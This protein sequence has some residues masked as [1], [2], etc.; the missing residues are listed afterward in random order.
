ML[1]VQVLLAFFAIGLV[2][3][4]GA[5]FTYWSV[6]RA[7]AYVQRGE[8]ADRTLQGYIELSAL[9]EQLLRT[10]ADASFARGTT[11]EQAAALRAQIQGKLKAIRSDIVEEAT[12]MARDPAGRQTEHKE[13]ITLAFLDS[14]L[15]QALALADLAVK[16][17]VNPQQ[18]WAAGLE[19]LGNT[20]G[21]RFQPQLARL[22][23][24][25]QEQIAQA[26]AVAE[27]QISRLRIAALIYAVASFLLLAGLAYY[28]SSRI[29]LP[30]TALITGTRT[31]A[32]GDLDARVPVTRADEFGQIAAN[33]NAIAQERQA[34]HAQLLAQQGKL[35]ASVNARTEELRLAM[36]RL[37]TSDKLRRELFADISHE[38]RTP[39]TAIRG[40]AEI[41]LRSKTADGGFYRA[42]LARVNDVSVQFARLIDDLLFVS[43][44]DSG[45]HRMNMRVVVLP[46][47]LQSVC[48]EARA[49]AVGQ[50]LEATIVLEPGNPAVL[51]FG[52][53]DRLH[54]LF[55]I[56]IDNAICYSLDA[57]DVRVAYRIEGDRVSVTVADRG[58]GIPQ[59]DLASVF[60]RFHRGTDAQRRNDEGL[61]LGLPIAKAIVDA[62]G[63]SIDIQ[64]VPNE[65]TTVSVTLGV[66]HAPRTPA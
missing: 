29:R 30:F 33:I 9:S 52:D 23:R 60:L 26:V 51:V 6:S 25:E 28:F 43:R 12:T 17:S 34:H 31:M 5:V 59:A 15:Q 10:I 56:L 14:S 55:V 4:A 64:S 40:E 63:G 57:I 32:Q 44:T 49:L 61:G 48:S 39:L 19:L 21:D 20:G 62:H 45:S 37:Q 53:Y 24:D 41:A 27:A 36:E 1:R 58:M 11:P 16:G 7:Q 46:G 50:R 47:L 35:E 2:V 18:A 54:Q 8:A 66:V 42:A 13:L 3:A 38:L 22:I 65:G